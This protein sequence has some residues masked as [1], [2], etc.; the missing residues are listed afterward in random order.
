MQIQENNRSWLILAY[1][2]Q[3]TNLLNGKIYIGKTESQDA[4]IHLV[5]IQEPKKK[6]LFMLRYENME[7]IIFKLN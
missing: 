7:F 1:I 2:Y 6:D 5:G 3:I 4:N